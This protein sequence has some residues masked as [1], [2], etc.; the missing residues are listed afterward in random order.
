MRLGLGLGLGLGQAL[1]LVRERDGSN[2][3]IT[4]V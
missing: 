1:G 3:L 4:R 2:Q